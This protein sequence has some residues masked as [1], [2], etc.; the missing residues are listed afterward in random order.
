MKCPYQTITIHKP[1]YLE[2]YV[3]HYAQ[4]IIQFGECNKA[5]CPFY[6]ISGSE[7]AEHCQRAESEGKEWQ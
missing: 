6:Y 7:K 3:T 4:D 5:E 2:N 1:K